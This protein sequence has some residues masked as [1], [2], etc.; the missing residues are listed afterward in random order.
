MYSSPEEGDQ[1]S[2]PVIVDVAAIVNDTLIV[3]AIPLCLHA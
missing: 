1:A 2:V 3:A